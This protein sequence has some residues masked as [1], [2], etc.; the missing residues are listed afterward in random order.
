MDRLAK[1]LHYSFRL[2]TQSPGFT[3][4]AL[5]SLALG[6]GANTAIFTVVNQVLL[7]P[8][9][10]KDPDRIVTVL[11]QVPPVVNPTG[12]ASFWS[13]PKFQALREENQVLAETA[14]VC[15]QAYGLSGGSE[16]ERL[17]VEFVSASYFPILGIGAVT[18]RL[19][20]AEEDSKPGAH[21]V[22]VI[23]YDLWRRQFGGQRKALGR[24][25]YV[26]GKPFQLVGVTPSGFRGQTGTVDIWVPMMMAPTLMFP[27]R[28]VNPHALWHEAIAR[29]KPGISLDQANA[30]LQLTGRKIEERFAGPHGA[31]S[32]EADLRVLPLRDAN[33]DPAIRRSILVVMGAVGFVLLI[34]CV[35]VANI[36]LA[37]AT[38][39]KREIATRLALGA[40]RGR[41]VRQ[42]FTEAFVLAMAGGLL[43]L[44]LAWWGTDL[45]SSIQ[46]VS[47][48]GFRAKDLQTL[49]FS[50]A[51]M[52]LGVLVFTLIVSTLSGLLSGI[53]PSLRLSVTDVSQTLKDAAADRT[54]SGQLTQGGPRKALVIG[55]IA[56]ALVLLVCAGLM[57]NSLLRLQ[58]T[59]GGFDPAGV[60]T[61]RVQLPGGYD[62]QAFNQQLLNKVS[63][64]PGV[65]S[66]AVSGSTPLSSNSG[67]TLVRVAGQETTGFEQLPQIATHN[68]SHDY[69]KT[70]GIPL[71]KGRSFTNGDRSNAPRVVIVNR[72]AAAQLWPGRDPLGQ[73]LWLAV[74]WDDKDWA[75]VIG[76]V[77]DVKYGKIEEA[78]EPAVY[79][80]YLQ[81]SDPSSFLLVKNRVDASSMIPALRRTVHSIDR[82]VP[83]FDVSTM[84]ERVGRASSITRFSALVLSSFAGL[85]LVLSMIGI[86]GVMAY[87]TAARSREIGIRLALGAK[88][89][90]LT[91]MILRDAFILAGAGIALGLVLSVAATKALAGQL[92]EI[93]PTD[94]LTLAAVCLTLAAASMIAAYIPAR[95]AAKSDPAAVLRA[96]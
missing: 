29:L 28:L 73:R 17:Q 71:L 86:Y 32:Q 80:S 10:Y 37:R 36:C 58:L 47:D 42:L 33:L 16:P 27:Q 22:A 8:L 70:L 92:Y 5:L 44:I 18:G 67:G 87:M 69:F 79:M 84:E 50:A 77:G 30:Q 93:Q 14:A 38:S 1:D 34:A 21:P 2:L 88:R 25:V 60:V 52:D 9:P 46:P 41:I 19:F 20:T 43:G 23:S 62:E 51:R 7:K 59:E 15:Q 55:Q 85:A 45:L 82:N 57:T 12:F 11:R 89:M 56:F 61:L 54:G 53:L 83:V 91:A 68:V 81:S 78:A 90:Q 94:P 24:T 6:I 72:K 4:I 66:A 13:Y 3:L 49:N 75:E 95:W 74:G 65:A 40:T 35:N 31:A 76:V 26:D 39:R 96:Q 64:L 63:A 48:A